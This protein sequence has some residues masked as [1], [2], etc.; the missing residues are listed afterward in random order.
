M[1]GKER[2]LIVQIMAIAR[3]GA[4]GTVGERRQFVPSLPVA[5]N[6]NESDTQKNLF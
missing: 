6:F 5:I 3:G 1:E 2:I 4:V